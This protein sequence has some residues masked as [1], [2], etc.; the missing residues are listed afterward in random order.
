MTL[1]RKLSGTPKYIIY[2]ILKIEL[3]KFVFFMNRKDVFLF[4][5]RKHR[6]YEELKRSVVG[7]NVCPLVILY[8]IVLR[9]VM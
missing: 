6:L 3:C 7:C 5:L 2:K 9:F 1:I 8:K 4:C